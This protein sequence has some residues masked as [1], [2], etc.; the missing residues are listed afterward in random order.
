MIPY[1]R[2]AYPAG[3]RSGDDINIKPARQKAS[4]QSKKFANG[5]LDPVSGYG[6]PYLFR[7]GNTKAGSRDLVVSG[8]D[9]EIIAIVSFPFPGQQSVL[10][11]G[12]DSI[13]LG[14]H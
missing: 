3:R 7:D 11:R 5:S 14:K 1:L 4:V 9:D 2:N 6:L 8:N 10:R 12:S 13:C